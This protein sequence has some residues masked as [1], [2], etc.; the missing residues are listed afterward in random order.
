[1]QVIA[2]QTAEGTTDKGIGHR[3]ESASKSD[4]P[5]HKAA[6]MPRRRVRRAHRRMRYGACG[7]PYALAYRR[8]H[9]YRLISLLYR[10]RCAGGDRLSRPQSSQ[11]R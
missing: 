4:S 10:G 5:N 2:K 8:Q 6:S 7:A 11:Q 1:L 9:R 3:W